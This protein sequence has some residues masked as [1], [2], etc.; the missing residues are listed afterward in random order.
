MGIKTS[1]HI[2][3]VNTKDAGDLQSIGSIK[4][5]RNVKEYEAINTGVVVQ[6]IGNIKTD[7]I[8]ISVLYAPADTAGAKEL[9]TAFNTGATVPFEI[10]LSDTLGVNGTTFGWTG[11]VISDFE[12]NQEEDGD[13][14]ASFTVA[15]NGKPAVT[16]AA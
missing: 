11:A 7:P 10:E 14:L 13:V 5:K 6:A 4:Q 9:E 2:V 15:L 1:G 3:R 16:A 8:A 12:L